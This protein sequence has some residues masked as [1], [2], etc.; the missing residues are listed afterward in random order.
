MNLFCNKVPEF[1]YTAYEDEFNQIMNS[2]FKIHG[3]ID[4]EV[5]VAFVSED[6]IRNIN[7]TYRNKDCITD[8]ISFAFD[9]EGFKSEA[10]GDI[11]I[12]T[13]KARKQA[14]EFNHS[15]M[16]EMCFLYCHGL[17]HLLGYD[18]QS[19]AEEEVMFKMQEDVLEALGIR[20]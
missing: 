9:E 19:E 8:V 3:I 14:F 17:L 15:L 11:I 18:H 16:R 13:E 12:C 5:S 4:R 6:E 10:L 7:K 20:R 1:D 2:V